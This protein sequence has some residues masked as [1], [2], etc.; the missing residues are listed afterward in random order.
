M[1]PPYQMCWILLVVQEIYNKCKESMVRETTI[2][3]G[4]AWMREASHL[5]I[6]LGFNKDMNTTRKQIEIH[7][8][9]FNIMIQ[10]STNC[11]GAINH[12]H[13]KIHRDMTLRDASPVSSNVDPNT[14]TSQIE[15]MTLAYI[16]LFKAI[17]MTCGTNIL[18]VRNILH[19]IVSSA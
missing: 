5:G 17:T 6:E 9:S 12:K 2:N 13:V 15:S 11:D 7:D 8:S 10:W 14:T 1:A 19:N 16:T 3:R 4:L 18:C